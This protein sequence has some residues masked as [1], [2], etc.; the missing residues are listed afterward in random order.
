[1][2]AKK[3]STKVETTKRRVSRPRQLKI[4]KNDEWLRPYEQAI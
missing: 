2:K 3:T 4:V 1:M